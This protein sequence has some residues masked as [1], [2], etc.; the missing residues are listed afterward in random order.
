MTEG[1]PKNKDPPRFSIQNLGPLNNMHVDLTDLVVLFGSP[2]TG[3]SYTMKSIYS[4]LIL[5]DEI[6]LEEIKKSVS[7]HSPNLTGVQGA[8]DDIIEYGRLNYILDLF[9]RHSLNLEDPSVNSF[10]VKILA[11]HTKRVRFDETDL[12]FEINLGHSVAY[13]KGKNGVF[14]GLRDEIEKR[15]KDLV[16][17]EKNSK[18]LIN[19]NDFKLF[20]GTNTEED[21][22]E[23][24][25]EFS[26]NRL[27]LPRR[28]SD[29]GSYTVSYLGG[30]RRE[31][32]I[33]LDWVERKS[34]NGGEG[35]VDLKIK[36]QFQYPD[37]IRK[38]PLNRT[39]EKEISDNLSKLD[40]NEPYFI[41]EYFSLL[42]RCLA[43]INNSSLLDNIEILIQNIK[44]FTNISNI[45]FVPFGRSIL[46]EMLDY[47]T[48]EPFS[49]MR[50]ALN[51][52]IS[53]TQGGLLLTYLLA[54]ERG[55]SVLRNDYEKQHLFIPLLQ[56]RLNV[57]KDQSI[58]YNKWDGS[59]SPLGIASALATEVTGFLLPFL[60]LQENGVILVEEPEAQLHPAAQFLMGLTLVALAK[61][62]GV[63][64]V[65]TTH[66]DIILSA[67]SIL[68]QNKP[69][70]KKITNV[71]ERILPAKIMTQ[72]D[73]VVEDFSKKLSENIKTID[74]NA[75][76][77]KDEGE[78]R[79]IPIENLGKEIPSITQVYET[80]ASWGLSLS[81]SKES[82]S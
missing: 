67:I 21:G 74:V 28:G 45:R 13:D 81:Y 37:R 69:D 20:L 57:N 22:V 16:I 52:L 19:N 80:I 71:L 39:I 9:Y 49:R 11:D 50:Y 8:K 70:A 55:R 27:P 43:K 44:N 34:Q 64:I 29:N 36:I 68:I 51:P 18:I 53:E 14:T 40:K 73:N 10:L 1:L 5:L 42:Q 31:D 78:A 66:S 12:S 76:W 30:M 82:E 15:I 4:S 65:L 2:N 35:L 46:I 62:K 3:K 23:K 17:Y 32:Q 60:T 59:S 72:Y 38:R 48:E 61:T 56:G 77:Y 47:V 6:M 7:D 75:Y 63:K 33:E 26:Y 79:E 41:E 54:A 58:L 25:L 24:R